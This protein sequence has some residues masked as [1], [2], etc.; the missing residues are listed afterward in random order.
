MSEAITSATRNAQPRGPEC[1]QIQPKAAPDLRVTLVPAAQAHSTVVE[2]VSATA[3]SFS[4]FRS[5]GQAKSWRSGRTL[6]A[7]RTAQPDTASLSRHRLLSATL[8]YLTTNC[9]RTNG[10]YV[11]RV[12]SLQPPR[13][14]LQRYRP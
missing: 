7:S 3:A 8:S 12:T 14:E 10:T 2:S 5:R 4:T 11:T 6:P 1:H 9:Q 13:R